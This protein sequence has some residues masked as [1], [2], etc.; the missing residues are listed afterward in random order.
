[1]MKLN[2]VVSENGEIY[3]VTSSLNTTDRCIV[4]LHGLSADHTLFDK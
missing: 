3:Y 2:S 1:M 4:F